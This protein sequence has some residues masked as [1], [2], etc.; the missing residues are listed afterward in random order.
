MLLS[1]SPLHAYI[2]KTTFPEQGVI[3]H[4]WD[5]AFCPDHL[6][7][8]PEGCSS[9]VVY[10]KEGQK[11]CVL[12]K[13]CAYYL[14][15]YCFIDK[16]LTQQ[17]AT[18]IHLIPK[19]RWFGCDHGTCD[20]CGEQVRLSMS[21]GEDRL[22][23][24]SQYKCGCFEDFINDYDEEER[25]NEM[26][27]YHWHFC[28]KPTICPEYF[29]ESFAQQ[30]FARLVTQIEYAKENPT[31]KCFWSE[32]QGDMQ[33]IISTIYCDFWY[34]FDEYWYPF[35]EKMEMSRY[36]ALKEILFA[37][38]KLGEHLCFCFS[39]TDIEE[40]LNNFNPLVY[41]DFSS[42]TKVTIDRY[43]EWKTEILKQ[44]QHDYLALCKKCYELHPHPRVEKEIS[45]LSQLVEK[46]EPEDQTC[47]RN[48]SKSEGKHKV[49]SCY[50]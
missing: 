46:Q 25:V 23:A 1:L 8:D 29:D 3:L 43:E 42:S 33:N 31:C 34:T 49:W 4:A 41:N 10:E 35:Y 19:I 20:I 24:A 38:R 18:D 6:I 17:L 36:E 48:S 14:Y 5:F 12:E 27:E 44:I 40:A 47:A 39:Y 21:L 32:S 2:D 13:E 30:N 50:Q 26:L 22:G 11:E 16:N 7:S 9:W 15:P 28:G 45:A 37:D